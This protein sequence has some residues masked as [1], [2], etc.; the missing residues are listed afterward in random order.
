MSW[1]QVLAD[2]HMV[3]RAV[4]LERQLGEGEM[5][6]LKE[7]R[8]EEGSGRR[9]VRDKWDLDHWYQQGDYRAQS[10]KT[11]MVEDPDGV[12]W[13]F[14]QVWVSNAADHKA[15]PMSQRRDVKSEVDK[16]VKEVA[17]IPGKPDKEETEEKETGQKKR[18]KRKGKRKQKEK[19]KES[20]WENIF[21][22]KWNQSKEDNKK[23]QRT[24]DRGQRTEDE[25]IPGK[26]DKEEKKTH[27]K[28]NSE[29]KIPPAI[30]KL[31]TR[32]CKGKVVGREK[33]KRETS[34]HSSSAWRGPRPAPSEVPQ[35]R[36]ARTTT[37]GMQKK[38]KVVGN[39]E[40]KESKDDLQ[41][42]SFDLR[43]GA[44]ESMEEQIMEGVW[45]AQLPLQLDTITP[46]DGNCFSRAVW[47]QCQRPEIAE[48]LPDN[49]SSYLDLKDRLHKFIMKTGLL[50]VTEMR[51]RYERD[52]APAGREELG[53]RVETWYAYWL[54][55]LQDRVWSDDVYIQGMAWFL[56]MD[57]H[58]VMSTA[59]PMMPLFT[60][61]G[62]WDGPDHTTHGGPLILGY[63][64]NV[65]YQS[66]LPLF[67]LQTPIH[68]PR[69][70]GETI[71][72]VRLTRAM[73]KTTPTTQ[74]EL[75]QIYQ[76]VCHEIGETDAK[77]KAA[78]SDKEI[79]E[80]VRKTLADIKNDPTMVSPKT[81]PELKEVIK[82][83]H[84]DIDKQAGKAK[85][86]SFLPKMPDAFKL[87]GV[88]RAKAQAKESL[89][90]IFN[91]I[92]ITYH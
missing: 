9:E 92:S 42:F 57:I 22:W 70:I 37:E 84:H 32:R 3:P 28:K 30:I 29:E 12:S 19:G 16:H 18:K 73:Q 21:K 10:I 65:H 69:T 2:P 50:V 25:K 89:V 31:L 51:E 74:A 1:E 88:L 36:R 35:A 26:L 44:G 82:A 80:L 11:I 66:L 78:I 79:I 15:C 48:L 54:R 53:G 45:R 68:N 59:T 85:K 38:D 62:S 39:K 76:A 8:W 34:N 41:A 24:E 72:Q 43:G 27:Q 58:I 52:V 81:M 5:A 14:V 47:S 60:I 87:N 63:I 17:K 56:Q 23:R 75:Q 49:F 71:F 86:K 90:I 67:P 91:F 7:E 83:V 40:K 77:R 46:G 55:M 61:S 4:F 13:P 20:T 64:P 33:E 6:R